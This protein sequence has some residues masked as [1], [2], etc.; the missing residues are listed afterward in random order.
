MAFRSLPRPSSALDAKAFTLCSYSLD[1]NVFPTFAF[2]FLKF[3]FLKIRLQLF[4]C[5]IV[6][7]FLKSSFSFLS[8]FFLLLYSFFAYYIVFNVLIKY[9]TKLKNLIT[10]LVG[11]SRLELPTSRLS[12]V[13]SNLLSYDPIKKSFIS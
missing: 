12:G 8:L 4:F 7:Q 9:I 13:C 10:Y 5:K 3:F 2:S 1:R 6:T 11:S